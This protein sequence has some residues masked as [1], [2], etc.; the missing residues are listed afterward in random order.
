MKKELLTAMEEKI[1]SSLSELDN[2]DIDSPE[3]SITRQTVCNLMDK[4]TVVEHDS[5]E[6]KEKE[7]KRKLEETRDEAQNEIERKKLAI[8]RSRIVSTA[9]I[10]KKKAE[11]ERLKLQQ[12][13]KLEQKK[14]DLEYAK[15]E[16]EKN[17]LSQT[18]ELERSKLEMEREKLLQQK[19]LELKKIEVEL[20]R[21][22]TMID[23]EKE[24]NLI[25]PARAV[26]DMAKIIVPACLTICAY[27]G[28][29]K[30]V[31]D[32]EENGRITSTAGRELHLPKF[33]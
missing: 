10:E 18:I 33:W 26:L 19:E 5:S 32:F 13:Y 30:R 17:K 6:Y 3:Y 9:E 22:Q 25:T 29:Q 12:S 4:L 27:S 8:D 23:V 7:S 2:Y 15:L 11:N 20:Q 1:Y 28:F 14:I 16:A 31:I 24:R 21:L